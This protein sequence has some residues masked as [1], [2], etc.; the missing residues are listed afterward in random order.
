MTDLHCDVAIIG[1]GTAG[2]A[3][4]RAARKAGASTLLID[5][6][7][8]GTTCATVGCMPSKLLIA[9]AHVA[10][11][12]RTAPIF[13]IGAQEP[14][15]DGVAVMARVRKER[16]AFVAATIEAIDR[17]PDG[18]RQRTRARFVDATT[19]LL[20][21]GHRIQAKAI[22]I[23]TG[24]RPTVPPMF[25]A[26]GDRVLSNENIFELTDLPRSVA[27]VGAGPIGLELAQAL[28]RLGVVVEV[29]DRSE[30]LAALHDDAVMA[31]LQAILSRELPFHL[32]VSI[33]V[34]RQGGA[35]KLAWTGKS[36]GE[37]IFDYVLVA[38]GRPPELKGLDLAATGLALDEHGTPEFSRETMQCG[39]SSIFLAG[40]ADA[41]RTVLHE[42]S[43]EGAI[44]GRN[45]ASFPNV[46]PA[47][48]GPAFSIMFTDPP[49]AVLGKPAGPDSVIGCA[50][51]AD[52]GRA[53]VEARNVGMARIYAER[54]DGRLVGAALVGPS[55]DH[56]AHLLAWAIDR[57][58]TATAL[59]ELPFYHP[60]LEEGIKSA[61]R[62][63]C[64]E[65]HTP[66]PRDRDEGAPAGG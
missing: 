22:V 3:A 53:K 56:I 21:D 61:L 33:A 64:A 19:L 29:F 49:V 62:Q 34:E 20:D 32:A 63:I 1:A 8:A 12:V 40:D 60:T 10:H 15:I 13:G 35:V 27:V 6:R 48:R 9:A 50:S 41:D 38:T 11:A 26:L 44:A 4:E 5:D 31:E 14:A 37:K 45:A 7:F 36:S 16:D 65:V 17:I 28:V 43:A 25:A 47:A 51:Y 66:L 58:E 55:M 57:G 59:L 23:A 42:A 46:E 24:S 39:Q 52:Q 30:R 18:I 2:L 54:P